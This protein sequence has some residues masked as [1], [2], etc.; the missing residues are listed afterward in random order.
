MISHGADI[1]AANNA[2]ETPLQEAIKGL[3]FRAEDEA[4]RGRGKLYPSELK[5]L[6]RYK[7]FVEWLAAKGASE[8]RKQGGGRQPEPCDDPGKTDEPTTIF[9]VRTAEGVQR[10]VQAG[11]NV[12][13]FDDERGTPLHRA[14]ENDR[15]EV[16]RA[17][18]KNGAKLNARGMLEETP[19]H[20]AAEQGRA[21]AS[22]VLLEA[23][24]SPNSVN[25]SGYT[26]LHTLVSGRSFWD[27]PDAMEKDNTPRDYLETTRILLKHGANA[28]AKAEQGKPPLHFAVSYGDVDLVKMLISAGAGVQ[29]RTESGAT[30]LHL[31]ASGQSLWG[32]DLHP[33][34]SATRY[35]DIALYL[36]EHGANV[37]ATDDMKSTSLY[38]AAV[39]C[40]QAVAAVLLEHGADIKA[41]CHHGET[42]LA[43]A[44]RGLSDTQSMAADMPADEVTART[45]CHKN[46]IKWLE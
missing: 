6:E 26:P 20:V 42:P 13:A 16:I 34:G 23:G 22:L 24:A 46:L 43:G 31:A 27:R 37:N 28:E 41:T 29:T 3:E 1:N 14:A 39:F 4:R 35:R 11:A 8:G 45:E 38:M 36:L 40:D 12:N 21:N 19:L 44:K 30:A 32:N 18:V 10:L 7:S 15:P 9:N 17:L 2:G 5:E 25:M 33:S